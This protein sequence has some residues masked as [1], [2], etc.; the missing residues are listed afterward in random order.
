MSIN[1]I[2]HVYWITKLYTTPSGEKRAYD[3]FGQVVILPKGENWQE[4]D[5]LIEFCHGT[6]RT[7][8]ALAIRVVS[9]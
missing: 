5:A 4:G 6:R 9:Q 3:Q 7:A 2:A 1:N 8:R